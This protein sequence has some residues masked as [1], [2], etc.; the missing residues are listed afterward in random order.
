[1]KRSAHRGSAGLDR[2]VL[3]LLLAAI[4]AGLTLAVTASASQAANSAIAWGGDSSGQLGNGMTTNSDVPASVS[5][6][7]G[8]EAI[9]AGGGHGLALMSNGTVMAWGANGAGQVGDGTTINKDTPIPVS[10]LSGVTAISAGTGH[11]L[12]LLSNGTVMAWGENAYEQLG[13]GTTVNKDTPVPVKD[14]SGVTAISASKGNFSAALLSD[15]TVVTWGLGANGQLGDGTRSG[16]GTPIHVCAVGAT[17]PC[18][19]GPYLSGV[20]AIS[21][22]G[23]H[24]LALLTNGTVVAWGYGTSGQLGTGTKGETDVPV[25]VSELSGVVAVSAGRS[26]SLALLSNGTAMAWGGNG[27]DELGDGKAG[28]FVLAPIP[29]KGLSGA[30]A[31]SAGEYHSLALLGDGS[32]M[33]WGYGVSGEIGDGTMTSAREPVAVGVGDITGVAAGGEQSLA[34]GPPAP[35][36]TAISPRFGLLAGGTSV[37]ITGINFTGATAVKFGTASATNVTVNSPTSITASSPAGAE[38]TPADVTVTTP[39][40]TSTTNPLDR[41][42]YVTSLTAPEYGRCVKVAL[43]TGSYGN[44]G[45]TK[46]GGKGNYEWHPGI[47]G[48]HFTTQMKELAG[49]ALPGTGDGSAVTCTDETGPGE[50]TGSRTVGDVVMTFTGCARLGQMCTS[51]AAAA[52]EVVTTPLEGVLGITALGETSSKNKVGVDLAPAGHAGALMEF[53][54]GATPISVRGSVISGPVSVDGMKLTSTLT[55]VA[56]PQGLQRP[57]AFVEEP[58]DVLEA[59]FNGGAF[60]PAGLVLKTILTNEEPLEIN[61]VV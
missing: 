25:P 57:D 61:S 33:A 12:A 47:A 38:G 35:V 1:M 21:T 8:V 28:G 20:M 37:S 34:F 15:G 40:G 13:D 17:G 36:V 18:P 46:L 55:F 26:Y 58:D 32:V 43:G 51:P 16:P 27:A 10:G 9:S 41:F 7:S 44:A 4:L 56:S 6:L 48:G 5:G 42:R 54:C 2:R 23:Y 49:I 59:S 45:C 39:E 52:G 19:T 24:T 30:T 22:G 11:S 53:D 50:Y 14:L 31:I 60:T 29:V 3:G